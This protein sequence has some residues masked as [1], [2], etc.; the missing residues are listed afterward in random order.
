MS[1]I[2]GAQLQPLAARRARR[3]RARD[4]LGL[5]LAPGDRPPAVRLA[6][7]QVGGDGQGHGRRSPRCTA[8]AIDDA[9]GRSRP[10]RPS[11]TTRS[12]S[13]SWRPRPRS[14]RRPR[15][16]PAKPAD[17]VEEAAAAPRRRRAPGDHGRHRPLLGARR[18]GAA[19]ARRGARASRSSSTAWA[20]AACP[21]TTSSASRRARGTGLEGG[22]RRAGDRRPARLPAR[23]R[24]LVRRGDEAHLAR[25]RAEP[26]STATRQPD[27][28]LVGDIAADARRA[29]ARPRPSARAR[30]RPTPGSPR[31]ARRSPRSAPPRLQRARRRPRPA[32]PDARL[33]G[34]RPRSSTATRS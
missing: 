16:R 7:R 18:G 20:A 14:R 2:A 13:S 28:E 9:I 8:A 10:A 29:S 24:R 17:G 4:A 11:S 22:R 34:A 33:Q 15:R 1:A 32:A 6:A 31:C 27:L 3:P 21:P 19:R 23:L 5:G 12:T 30:P 26:S 25:R